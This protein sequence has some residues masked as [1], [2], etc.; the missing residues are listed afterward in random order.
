VQRHSAIQLYEYVRWYV[1]SAAPI[2]AAV[3]LLWFCYPAALKLLRTRRRRRWALQQGLAQRIAVAYAEY[4]DRCRDLAVGDPNATPVR[5]L[6]D[7]ADDAEHSELAWLVA[8]AL[9]GDLRRDLRREDV[10]AAERLAAS[11]CRR[12]S[13]A[14]PLLTRGLATVARTSLR[15]PYSEQVP[16]IRLRDPLGSIRA[17]VAA[18][19]GERVRRR[20]LRRALGPAVA[21]AVIA[22]L[23]VA[24]GGVA[25][26]RGGAVTR[27]PGGLVPASLSGLAFARLPVAEKQYRLSDPDALISA[28]QVYVIKQDDV[29]Q[30]DV[31]LTVLK[32]EIDTADF[33]D[34]RDVYCAHNYGDCSGLQ[35]FAGVQSSLGGGLHFQRVY[36][37]AQRIYL[38]QLSDQRVYV[39]Y[40]RGRQVM[41][42][43][44]VRKQF[45]AAA[46]DQVVAALVD[47]GEKRPVPAL[48]LPPPQYTSPS[49]SPTGGK[50]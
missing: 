11:V 40:P 36:H 9:W 39:W 47:Y 27:V 45:A 30:G 19:R 31:Q 28:G 6:R 16:N 38:L 35:L 42:M 18:W 8:R 2:A 29:T 17:T 20:R 44:V 48:Q 49:P 13:R 46:A 50:P 22:L 7:F 15:H 37:G 5:F 43:V 23:I 33:D 41:M 3:F 14:Q 21:G 1:G 32:P 4:R 25:A 12:V 34:S 10:E 24:C 26:A